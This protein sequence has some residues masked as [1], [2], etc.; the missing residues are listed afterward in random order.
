MPILKNNEIVED[1]ANNLLGFKNSKLMGSGAEAIKYAFINAN[2]KKKTYIVVPVTI[3]KSV[4]DTILDYGCFPLFCDVDDEFCLNINMLKNKSNVDIS[5]IIYVHAYGLLKDI[6]SLVN[7]CQKNKYIL[8]EDSAQYFCVDRKYQNM[9]Q[10][11]FVVFSFG[12][13][14]PISVGEYGLL[15]SN[16]Y[17]IIK[18]PII[19][20][21]KK[22]KNLYNVLLQA[23][24]RLIKKQEKVALYHSLLL[25]K[26]NI[27]LNQTFKDNIYHRLLYLQNNSYQDISDKMYRYMNVEK[28][29]NFQSTIVV[30]AFRE[31]YLKNINEVIVVQSLSLSEYPNYARLKGSCYYFRTHDETTKKSIYKICKYFNNLLLND[32]VIVDDH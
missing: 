18:F 29:N 14:K 12:K 28:L 17:D 23:P 6:S 9:S 32:E 25:N 4:V 10:G 1:C 7:F 30:E 15:S 11:D 27:L 3:C 19:E 5:S 13:G 20:N 2:I 8:I 31:S 22:L 24:I 16:K 21:D 26:N